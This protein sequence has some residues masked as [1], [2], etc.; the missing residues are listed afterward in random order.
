MLLY[1]VIPRGRAAARSK[2]LRVGL[3]GPESGRVPV[4]LEHLHEGHANA[5]RFDRPVL[6]CSI[7]SSTP[8]RPEYE[9][10]LTFKIPPRRSD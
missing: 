7:P 2:R 3:E 6:I 8:I 4:A 10:L 1:R 5:G 9:V